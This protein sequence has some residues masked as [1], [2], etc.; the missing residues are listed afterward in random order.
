MMRPTWALAF[1]VV[2]HGA[3]AHAEPADAEPADAEPIQ[4]RSVLADPPAE[5]VD[6]AAP[7][8]AA[9]SIPEAPSPEAQSPGSP[10][11]EVDEPAVETREITALRIDAIAKQEVE[12]GRRPY[13]M[14]D[15][16]AAA[17]DA[18]RDQL[19]S[20]WSSALTAGYRD[21]RWGFFGMV[22]FDQTYDFT[23]D[24]DRVDVLN[25]GVGVELM[26]FL[27]HVRS[28]VAVGGSI[29][30]SD[31]SIDE[32]G[33]HGVFLD[34]RPAALRWPIGDQFVFEFSPLTFDVAVPVARE[35]P[36]IITSYNTVLAIEWAF[37]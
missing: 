14:L 9:V 7:I 4:P 16:G 25:L 34:F 30:L 22:E 23:F 27:G 13:V 36:L 32:A 24:V 12:R 15:L 31:T 29:L 37:P 18:R 11:V 17:F 28:A 33:E 8:G 10:P 21:A 19:I 1:A 20:R 26:S 3:A 2:A 35:L 5:N 6:P